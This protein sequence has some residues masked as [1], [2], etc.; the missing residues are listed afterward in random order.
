VTDDARN[1]YAPP[2]APLEKPVEIDAG[3]SI[4]DA[5]AGRYDFTIGEVMGEAWDLLHGFKGAFWGAALVV[6]I[7]PI[8]ASI[9]MNAVAARLYGAPLPF[10]L[11]QLVSGLLGALLTP[12]TVGLWVIAVRRAA[13][14]PNSFA[15]AFVGLGRIPVLVGAGLL[16]VFLTYLGFAL[17]VI[18]GIYLSLAYGMALPLL[19]FRNMPVWTALEASRRT[20][21]HKWFQIF[22]LYLIVGLIVVLS[23]L[24]LGIPL[25]WTT[26]WALLVGGVLY[27]KMFGV[28]APAS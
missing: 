26:P 4:E 24:P 16:T 25:I 10:L 5:I 14:L 15:M 19:A 18:P 22:G 9:V 27:R 12:L 1:P 3:G 6:F 8:I 13:G 2:N 17:L 21:T 7:L 11:N 20:I 23:A 28:P